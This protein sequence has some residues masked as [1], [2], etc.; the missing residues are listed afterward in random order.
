M[1]DLHWGRTIF[2]REQIRNKEITSIS[3]DVPQNIR[4]KTKKCKCYPPEMA[5]VDEMLKHKSIR[6][7]SRTGV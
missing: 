1:E 2:A 4:N 3:S 6:E 5:N 7:G